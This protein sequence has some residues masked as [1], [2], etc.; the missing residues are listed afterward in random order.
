MT[1]AVAVLLALLI[2]AAT[3]FAATWVWS[4]S[5]NETAWRPTPF[6]LA[7]GFIT[8][9]FDTLGIGS[10]ATTTSLYRLRRTVADEKLPGTLNVGHCL[11][12]VAQALIFLTLVEVD[13]VTLMLLIVSAVLGAWFG[14]GIVARLSRRA[15]RL[16]MGC[17]LLIAATLMI[18]SLTGSMPGGGDALTLRGAP[19]VLGMAGNVLFGALM[20]LGIGAYAP[21][22]IMVSLLGMNPVAAFPI[23]M[24]SC[25]FLTTVGNVQFL[26]AG[27]YDAPA[28]I[29]LTLGGIPAVLLAAFLVKELPLDALRWIVVAV[30]VYTACGLLGAAQRSARSA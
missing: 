9:F 22:M 7:V 18:L 28:A 13:P 12:T 2:V 8:N 27:A 20:T 25:A 17:G 19:L 21:I 5:R 1:A 4:L 24:S 15:I 3:V 14:A 11:P 23:M 30:V 26:R 29:G 10:F 6:N 16:G